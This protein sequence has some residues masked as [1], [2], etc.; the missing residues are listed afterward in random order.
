MA[1]VLNEAT[2]MSLEGPHPDGLIEL[3]GIRKSYFNGRLETRVL[4]GLDALIKHGDYTAIMGQSGSG[5]STLMNI[6]GCLDTPTKGQYW[7]NGKDVSKLSKAQLATVRNETIGFVFQS[8]NLLKR[9]TVIDNVALPL[10]YA[11]KSRAFAR[12]HAQTKL[13]IVG[14]G[15]LA[16]RRPAQLSGGQQQRVAIA[17][18]LVCDPPLLLADEPTGNL[19]TKTSDEI[20][21]VLK[22]LNQDRGLS[23]LIVTHEPDIAAH[24]KRLVRLK[25][26]LIIYDGPTSEGLRQ[27]QV[28]AANELAAQK[29]SG[30]VGVS[31]PV[32]IDKAG[33]AQ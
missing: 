4:H 27:M 16:E 21:E 26:G 13:D 8:F 32:Q 20:I 25:D 31:A 24:A 33:R 15:P 1:A 3:R 2:P 17:R 29:M 14:L 6:L 5:K 11:G 9:M 19:D 10:I 12:K 23:I 18:A 28:A 7:L 30:V 22:H